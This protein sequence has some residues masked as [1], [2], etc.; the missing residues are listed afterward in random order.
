VVNYKGTADGKPL[1]DL[2][3]TAK[4]LTEKQGFWVEIKAGSFI[5]GFTEQLAGTKAGDKK[6]INVDF[7]ADFVTPQLQGKKGAY[8]VEVTE[9]KER[10]LPELN[11]EFAKSFGAEDLDRLREGVRSDLQNEMNLKRKK[12]VRGQILQALMDSVNFD[13]PETLVQQ[14]TRHSVYDIVSNIQQQGAPKEVIE[15]QK[16]E[17]YSVASRNAKDR[18]KLNLLVDRIAEKEGIRV[19]EQELNARLVFLAGQY[20][21]TPDKFVKELEK[22]AGVYEIHRQLLNEKVVDFLAENAKI[23][24]VPPGQAEEKK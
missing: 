9:V 22:G 4:G 21:M 16:E 23:E 20:K 8:E 7:P 2:A 1:T 3:P 11:N 5:P 14:E 12:S 13:L 10:V 17:I 6:T 15:Q 18:V 19:S 24:D